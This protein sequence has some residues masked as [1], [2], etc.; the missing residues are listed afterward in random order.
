MKQ[1]QYILANNILQH[2]LCEKNILLKSK[3]GRLLF[4]QVIL[5]I[6]MT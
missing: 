6:T 1:A 5:W 2:I 4:F 3:R